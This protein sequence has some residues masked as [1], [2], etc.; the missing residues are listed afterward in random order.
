MPSQ[1]NVRIENIE[2]APGETINIRSTLANNT[3]AADEWYRMKV[4]I[5]S[6]VVSS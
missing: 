4:F 5:A 2:I 3:G 1:A 6:F